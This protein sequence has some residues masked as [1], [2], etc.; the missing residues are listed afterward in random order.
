MTP[1][2]PAIQEPEAPFSMRRRQRGGRRIVAVRSTVSAM[3]A[4][5][6]RI[7]A[8]SKTVADHIA[9]DPEAQ[10]FIDDWAIPEPNKLRPAVVLQDTELF[11]PVYST[12][13]VVTMTDR[14]RPTLQHG[15]AGSFPSGRWAGLAFLSLQ[16]QVPAGPVPRIRPHLPERPSRSKMELEGKEIQSMR[17]ELQH[18]A[19]EAL[20]EHLGPA[21]CTVRVRVRR[22]PS[23]AVST[24]RPV[25]RP[26]ALCR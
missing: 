2:D 26:G 18:E 17:E 1:A 19:R 16:R 10:A 23:A 14:Q 6:A 9:A 20:I 13:L 21:H 4:L 7:R 11:D 3:D 12:L 25:G 8:Q 24:I 22:G 15:C 5:R